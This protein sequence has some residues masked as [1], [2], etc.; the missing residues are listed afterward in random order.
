MAEL[1]KATPNDWMDQT[2]KLMKSWNEQS[3]NLFQTWAENLQKPNPASFLAPGAVPDSLQ[4]PLSQMTEFFNK[5]MEQWNALGQWPKDKGGLDASALKKLFDPAEW[6]RAGVGGFDLALEH[7]TEGPT[8]ATL[9]DLDRKLLNAQRLSQQRL[10]DIATYQAIMQDAWRS[11]SER[12]FRALS[13]ASQQ[14]ISSAR[15]LLDLWVATANETLIEMHRTPKFLEAQGNVTR[16]SVDYRLQERAIAETFCEVHHIPTRSEVDE[17]QRTVME[18]RR[19]VRALRTQSEPAPAKPAR[20]AKTARKTQTTARR[21][22][23]SR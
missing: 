22:K 14:P 23:G 19:Q 17:L 1:A 3:Q 9:W 12:F 8:Y 15:E 20:T 21:R 13:D 11:A 5:S 2:T 10:R 6:G 18:L 4:G 16:S 7:L